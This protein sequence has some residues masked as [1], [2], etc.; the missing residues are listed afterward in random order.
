MKVFSFKNLTQEE[1]DL[2]NSLTNSP[3][4]LTPKEKFDNYVR[5]VTHGN[6]KRI[7]KYHFKAIVCC[8]KHGI[9][10]FNGRG[11]EL[12]SFGKSF[13]EQR[14]CRSFAFESYMQAEDRNVIVGGYHFDFVE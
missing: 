1:F 14:A 2:L 8:E 7:K 6:P 13:E 10:L 5:R 12:R 9:V 11:E 4:K 3:I